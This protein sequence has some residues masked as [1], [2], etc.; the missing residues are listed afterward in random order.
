MIIQIVNGLEIFL[1]KQYFDGSL[2]SIKQQ[3][4]HFSRTEKQNW[5]RSKHTKD[6]SVTGNNIFSI[7]LDNY[8]LAVGFCQ[9][10]L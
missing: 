10:Q 7:K 4:H 8:I 6:F 9:H 3:D 5:N 1:A 2:V